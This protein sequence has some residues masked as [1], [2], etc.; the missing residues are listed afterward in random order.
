MTAVIVLFGLTKVKGIQI[1]S[2]A[3]LALIYLNSVCIQIYKSNIFPHNIL[4]TFSL[5][6]YILSNVLLTFSFYISSA[7]YNCTIIRT[8]T[9]NHVQLI[10]QRTKHFNLCFL[11]GFCSADLVAI[12]NTSRTPSFVFAEHSRYA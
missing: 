9:T 12:S 8:T 5:Y 2:V 11:C 7:V 1:I 4:L 10:F 3:N 6:N